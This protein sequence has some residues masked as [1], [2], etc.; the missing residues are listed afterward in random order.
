MKNSKNE[1]KGTKETEEYP[2][3]ARVRALEEALREARRALEEALREEFPEG[4]TLS[5]KWFGVKRRAMVIGH[6]RLIRNYIAMLELRDLE[7]GDA[8]FLAA[9]DPFYEVAMIEL[10]EEHKPT[11]NERN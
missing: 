1:H 7:S 2:G 5:V 8:R 6:G 3:L 11:T 4:S 9:A 10:P